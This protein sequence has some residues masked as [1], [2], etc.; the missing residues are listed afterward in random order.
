MRQCLRGFFIAGMDRIHV[1]MRGHR[2]MQPIHLAIGILEGLATT[3]VVVFVRKA[4]PEILE[5]LTEPTPVGS[6]PVR[7]LLIGLL[8]ATVII[9]GALSWFASSHPD[10]LEWAMFR[11]AET[12]ELD[13]PEKGIHSSLGRFQEKTAFL[14][15][16]GFKAE[17][18]DNV[19]E[20]PA[21]WPAADAGTTVSGLVGGALT[22]L[23]AVL[24]GFAIERRKQKLRA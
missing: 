13:V 23:M 2:L 10:G 15:D 18:T 3:A 21:S 12:E 17:G 22:L 14:P 4:R 1:Q 24:I 19:A 9:G 20:S 8:A 7:K 11:A 6:F 16:Y 5:R